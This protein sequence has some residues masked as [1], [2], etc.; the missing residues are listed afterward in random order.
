MLFSHGISRCFQ[1]VPVTCF[2][3]NSLTS[4][5]STHDKWPIKLTQLGPQALSHLITASG[6]D[7]STSFVFVLS[8]QLGSDMLVCWCS[9]TWPV[10]IGWRQILNGWL[11][12]L[13]LTLAEHFHLAHHPLSCSPSWAPVN[14]AFHKVANRHLIAT[15][16][17]IKYMCSDMCKS[18]CGSN[19]QTHSRHCLSMWNFVVVSILLLFLVTIAV[20]ANHVLI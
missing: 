15:A 3:N 17:L 2:R 1:P 13:Y 4:S 11:R 16:I 9:S 12:P 20:H 19:T 7:V 8:Q 14:I 18:W 5:P 6:R 10:Q